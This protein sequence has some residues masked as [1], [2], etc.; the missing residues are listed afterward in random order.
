MPKNSG[1]LTDGPVSEI[2]S[3]ADSPCPK[4]VVCETNIRIRREPS[5]PRFKTRLT[6]YVSSLRRGMSSETVGP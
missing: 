2:S 1:R 5:K 3:A 4:T 6:I